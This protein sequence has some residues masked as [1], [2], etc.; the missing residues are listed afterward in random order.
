MLCYT[1][2]L[3]SDSTLI[4]GVLTQETEAHSLRTYDYVT[5][6]KI[7]IFFF[8]GY[9]VYVKVF[10]WHSALDM[11]GALVRPSYEAVQLWLRC[12]NVVLFQRSL[13]GPVNIRPQ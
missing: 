1:C 10:T 11:F 5:L 7:N 12:P 8:A 2:C 9:F 6:L 3:W 4:V 13:P